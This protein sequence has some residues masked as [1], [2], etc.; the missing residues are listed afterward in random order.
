[1]QLSV[2][3]LSIAVMFR[4]EFEFKF[5]LAMQVMKQFQADRNAKKQTF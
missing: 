3:D 1:M 2:T 4:E 5:N